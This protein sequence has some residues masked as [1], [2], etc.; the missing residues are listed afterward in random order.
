MA[1]YRAAFPDLEVSVRD[2][3]GEGD[4]V[5]TEHTMRGTHRGGFMGV[6]PTRRRLDL[7]GVSIAR[8]AG[9]RVAEAWF[10]WDR[11]RLLEQLGVMPEVV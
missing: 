7:S 2:Q 6:P 8:V 10:E 11:R 4:A 5:V 9:G 3:F 1:G